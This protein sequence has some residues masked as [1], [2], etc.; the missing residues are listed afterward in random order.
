MYP[1][2]PEGTQVILGS[3]NM[4]YIS[5]TARNRTHNLFRPKRYL[6]PTL[7][8]LST[9]PLKDYVNDQYMSRIE[10]YNIKPIILSLPANTFQLWLCGYLSSIIDPVSVHINEHGAVSVSPWYSKSSQV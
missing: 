3:M 2:N 6:S 5:D 10:Y 8:K 9:S 1:V 7:S 4:G